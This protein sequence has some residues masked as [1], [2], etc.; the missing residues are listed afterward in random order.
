MQKVSFVVLFILG[1]ALASA[2]EKQQVH[3][4]GN[5]QVDF[6]SSSRGEA[7]STPPRMMSMPMDN[8]SEGTK[9]PWIAAG[10]SLVVPGAGEIY[11]ENYLKGAVFIAVEAT[12]WFI[13]YKYDKKGDRATDDFQAYANQHW[14]AVRYTNWTLDHLNMLNPNITTPV[15]D[16]HD[17]IYGADNPIVD[18]NDCGPPFDCINWV[19]QSKMERDVANG[20]TN[21]YTH[22]LPYWN[23][24]QYYELIGKYKQFYSGWDDADINVRPSDFEPQ[25]TSRFKMYAQTRADANHLY[26]V[27][28]TWVSIA[29]INHV[30]SAIDAYWSA[31]RY[32]NALHAEL[33]MRFEQTP[34]GP[35]PVTEAKVKYTF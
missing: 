1:C 7:L 14:N 27:A 31:T 19:E 18:P 17:N 3:L 34:Y 15:D 5:P 21:G 25:A 26:D 10:L 11:S 28:S 35:V 16:Y 22:V 9:S 33:K 23:D 30:V 4:T 2:G 29:V 32:N 6:F 20:A 13:A 24:Q 12:S 8:S